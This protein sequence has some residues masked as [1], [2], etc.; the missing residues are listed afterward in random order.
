MDVFQT[1]LLDICCTLFAEDVMCHKLL[2][3]HVKLQQTGNKAGNN[4]LLV[5]FQTMSLIVIN[6]AI[7]V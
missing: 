4:W 3:F 2:A 6:A 1:Q 5:P 7:C